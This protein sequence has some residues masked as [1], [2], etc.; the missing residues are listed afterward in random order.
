MVKSP[1]EIIEEITFDKST[2][3]FSKEGIV[4]V[5][6]HDHA[7]VDLPDILAEHKYL[8]NK[9]EYLPLRLLVKPGKSTSI[10]SEVREFINLPESMQLVNCQAILVDNLAHKILASFMM[11]LYKQPNKFKLFSDESQAIDWLRKQ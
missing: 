8:K 4:I 7:F 5:L 9:T 10:S 2:Y 3:Q 6:V 11:K 1:L